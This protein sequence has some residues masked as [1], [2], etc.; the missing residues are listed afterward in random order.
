MVVF[1][2]FSKPRSPEKQ[3]STPLINKSR[4]ILA[5]LMDLENNYNKRMN[6]TNDPNTSSLNLNDFMNDLNKKDY[7]NYKD[8]L[9]NSLYSQVEYLRKDSLMKTECIKALVSNNQINSINPN[10][11]YQQHRNAII[12]DDINSSTSEHSHTESRKLYESI[13]SGSPEYSHSSEQMT[14]GLNKIDTNNQLEEIRKL[15]KS[16][17]YNNNN[18]NK[19][20]AAWEKHTTGFGSK[21]LHRMGYIG[22]GLGKHGDGIL[23]PITSNTK[24]DATVNVNPGMPS[25]GNDQEINPIRVE[26][27]VKPWPKNTTLITGSSMISGLNEKKLTR[28]NAKVRCFPG[29]SIDDMYDFLKPHIKKK[30]T[31]IILHISSNDST[32]KSADKIIEEIK[33]LKLYIESV[34][35]KVRLYLSCPIVRTDN[36]RANLTLREVDLY[37]KSQNYSVK[38][39]NIDNTCLGRKGLHL[40]LKGSGRLAINFISLMRRL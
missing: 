40:N 34:L 9:L 36:N 10:A 5:E 18:N 26:N 11:T 39:D 35:P 12:D 13:S 8:M 17:F 20:F 30:P 16:E 2:I 33:N 19:D 3:S 32:Q 23:N 28:Y 4:D 22:G 37:M 15:K 31:N 6:S 21:M 29:A 38:N 25:S 14:Y 1:G 27:E 7:I 24:L